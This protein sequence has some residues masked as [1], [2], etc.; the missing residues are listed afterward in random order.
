MSLLTLA[1]LAALV[2]LPLAVIGLT[3]RIS[4]QRARL[5]VRIIGVA[6]MCLLLVQFAESIR[7]YIFR[8]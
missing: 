5:V 2:I 8:H 3:R 4:S 7:R 6:G 1:I